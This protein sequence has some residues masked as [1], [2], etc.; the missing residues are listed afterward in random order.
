MIGSRGLLMRLST[1]PLS[2]FLCL[3]IV[4]TAHAG[5]PPQTASSSTQYV[6]FDDNEYPGDA[7]LP[8]LR[9]HFSFTGYWLNNPPG[10]DHNNWQGKRDLLIHNGFGFLVLAN[11]R[12]EADITNAKHSGTSPS[13]LGEK[14]AAAAIAAARRDHFPNHAILFL[15]QE[16]GGRLSDDQS[17]YLF[18][19]TQAVAHSGFLPGV[20]VS[21]QPVPDSPGKTITTAQYVRQQVA[22]HHLHEIAIWVYQDACPPAPGCTMQPP[23]LSASGTPDVVAWQYAQSP[24]RKAITASCS[25]TYAADGNC[26]APDLPTQTLDLSVAASSDPS[27]GR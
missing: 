19:W 25:K 20:Y 22:A 23:S 8:I 2:M 14:D 27:H 6:G 12:M 26:Y 7:A 11:G 24:R 5:S 18:A 4:T 21:G 1:I 3:T 16:E 17:A 10:D 13:T 9:R 15:D